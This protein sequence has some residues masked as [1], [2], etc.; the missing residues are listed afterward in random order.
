[1]INYMPIVIALWGICFALFIASICHRIRIGKLERDL[2]ILARQVR[3]N[4]IARR[5]A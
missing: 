3:Q 2:A 5:D 1:M 4:M